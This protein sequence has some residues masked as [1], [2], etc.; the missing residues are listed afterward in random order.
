MGK[1]DL[2]ALFKFCRGVVEADES[3]PSAT[4]TTLSAP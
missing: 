2:D 3:G 1:Q 4:W